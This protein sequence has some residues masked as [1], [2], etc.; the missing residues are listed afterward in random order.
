MQ[1]RE[2][3]Q[4]AC[5]HGLK[6]FHASGKCL[7]GGSVFADDS[8]E[9]HNLIVDTLGREAGEH[10]D[11]TGCPFYGV[12]QKQGYGEPGVTLTPEVVKDE[13]GK[14]CTEE[15]AKKLLRDVAA[16]ILA[17]MKEQRRADIASI[18]TSEPALR[19]MGVLLG[20]TADVYGMD[21]ETF[22]SHAAGFSSH[23]YTTTGAKL[24]WV[25]EWC[26][27]RG[28]SVLGYKLEDGRTT[29]LTVMQGEEPVE[30]AID[31]M[32]V[33]ALFDAPARPSGCITPKSRALLS[34]RADSDAGVA[35]LYTAC[36]TL[37]SA[38]AVLQTI[39]EDVAEG[40]HISECHDGKT[41]V[42]VCIRFVLPKSTTS[43]TEHDVIDTA[44][45]AAPSS[46]AESAHSDG[47][48]FGGWNRADEDRISR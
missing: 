13:G 30:I 36:R 37:D 44:T 15:R 43:M 29:N 2:L 14:P 31:G 38:G 35:D 32:R 41:N 17:E 5:G 40:S 21:P 42:V 25:M 33:E 27:E 34:A 10:H 18:S 24:L 12:C 6:Q 19:L 45:Q 46:A 11:E 47:D 3:Q 16:E 23:L 1:K 9:L 22:G 8:G 4:L 48:V 20:F 39:R 7:H 26:L 28:L